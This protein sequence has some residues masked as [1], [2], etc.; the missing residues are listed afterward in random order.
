MWDKE[1]VY[2]FVQSNDGKIEK[3]ESEK[4]NPRPH[5]LYSKGEKTYFKGFGFIPFF[6][7]GQ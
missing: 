3:D 1:Q 7:S 6:P 5:T 2:Y 4:I